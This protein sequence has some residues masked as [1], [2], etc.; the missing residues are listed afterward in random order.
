MSELEDIKLKAL[1]QD[2]KL[3]TPGTGFSGRVMNKIFESDNAL[4]TIKAQRILGKGFWLFL[5]LF[6]VLLAAIY[7]VS[8][9]GIITESNTQNLLPSMN[10]AITTYENFFSKIGT[11]PLSIAGILIA[12]SILLFIDRIISSNTKLFTK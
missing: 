8:G 1:L 4:E 6:I 5:A 7:F 11:A 2:M 9:A 12:A 3:E 10:G